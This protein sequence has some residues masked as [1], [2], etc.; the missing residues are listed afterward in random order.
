MQKPHKTVGCDLHVKATAE[1]QQDI[2]D[3]LQQ[4]TLVGNKEIVRAMIE[5]AKQENADALNA[6]SDG[7]CC[8]DKK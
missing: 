2:E 4:D 1:L 8:T 6:G 3:D 7:S 5:N